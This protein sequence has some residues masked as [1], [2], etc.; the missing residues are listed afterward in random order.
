MK[1]LTYL[2][3]LLPL[4]LAA[5]PTELQIETLPGSQLGCSRKTKNGDDVSMHYTGSLYETGKK[6][7][8]SHDRGS[9]L[10]FK[11]GSGRVIKG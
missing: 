4:A 5:A 9:P 1:L 8:S 10:E 6:F 7:D 11:L 3:F 2:S